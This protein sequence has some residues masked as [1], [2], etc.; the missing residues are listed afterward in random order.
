[1][2]LHTPYG[3]RVNEKM[4]TDLFFLLQCGKI[5]VSQIEYNVHVTTLFMVC[6]NTMFIS[7]FTK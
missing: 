6:G 1:M 2:I 7:T 5:N 4:H 3:V